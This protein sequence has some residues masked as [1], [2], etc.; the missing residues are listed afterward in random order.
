M[1]Q[2]KIKERMV[3]LMNI[4]DQSIQMVDDSSEL[5]MLACAMLQRTDEIFVSTL[6]CKGAI[7]MFEDLVNDKKNRLK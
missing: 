6:G 4:I 3:E 1:D 2:G 5:L 7:K